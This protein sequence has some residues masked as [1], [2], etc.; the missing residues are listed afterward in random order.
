MDV[1]VELGI[2]F[3]SVETVLDV[4]DLTFNGTIGLFKIREVRNNGFL[5]TSTKDFDV[6]VP[7]IG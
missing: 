7:K 3:K 2:S 1:I 6:A 5:E 4:T